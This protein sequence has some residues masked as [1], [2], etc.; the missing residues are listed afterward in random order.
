MSMVLNPEV[1]PTFCHLAKGSKN[2]DEVAESLAAFFVVLLFFGRG[3][4]QLYH[5]Q[6][7]DSFS[8][9]GRTLPETDCTSRSETGDSF[10]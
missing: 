8:R 6:R 7:G 9:K 2:V 10:G 4:I 1:N 5:F 3:Q